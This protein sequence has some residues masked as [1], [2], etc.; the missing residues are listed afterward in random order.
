MAGQL[1]I[2]DQAMKGCKDKAFRVVKCITKAKESMHGTLCYIESASD[3]CASS[4]DGPIQCWVGARFKFPKDDWFPNEQ[5]YLTLCKQGGS[6][7]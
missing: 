7:S 2:Y 5:F 1:Y 4:L 6:A 3:A